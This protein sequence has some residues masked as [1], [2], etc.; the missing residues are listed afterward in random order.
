MV[1]ETVVGFDP[2]LKE[3]TQQELEF[4]TD[5]RIFALASAFKQ[6]W[7]I[8]HLYQLTKIDPWFLYKLKG[9]IDFQ[10]HLE[11]CNEISR[12]DLLRAKQLG[13]SD[14]F[15]A[16]CVVSSELVIRKQRID[17]DIRPYVKKVDT[18]SAEWPASTNY[19]Y[20]TYNA[21]ESDIHDFG[22]VM[23]LG[24]GVYRIGSSVEFDCCAV[25]CVQ[26]LT[27]VFQHFTVENFYNGKFTDEQ[28]HHHGELQSGNSEH[29]LRHVQQA[30]L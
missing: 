19:L 22:G 17:Q 5:K 13:F 27:K 16:Q 21:T 24:S 23:V 11:S 12:P 29:R 8:D 3:A 20:L 2:N 7:N 1:D 15:I 4:P 9:I 10:K 6:N 25:G 30:V 26:E 14:K 18:V 28:N